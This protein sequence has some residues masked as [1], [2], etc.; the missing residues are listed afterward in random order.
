MTKLVVNPE[1]QNASNVTFANSFFCSVAC[2]AIAV[3]YYALRQGF[4]DSDRMPLLNFVGAALFVLNFPAI[5][6]ET[7]KRKYSRVAVHE[8]LIMMLTFGVIIGLASFGDQLSSTISIAGY[9]VCLHSFVQLLRLG[10]V[11]WISVTV[12]SIFFGL[13]ISLLTW[14]C[15]ENTMFLESMAFDLEGYCCYF[16]DPL[17]QAS[18]TQM[19]KTYGVS[20]TGLDGIPYIHYH[21]GSH[22]IFSRLSM[23]FRCHVIDTIQVAHPIIFIPLFAKSILLATSRIKKWLDLD[24]SFNAINY[25]YLVVVFVGFLHFNVQKFKLTKYVAGT[26]SD[27]PTF[28]TSESYLISLSA[29]IISIITIVE[30]FRAKQIG[31]L[32]IL[33][34]FMI[35]TISIIKISTGFILLVFLGFSFLRLSLYRMLSVCASLFVSSLAFFLIYQFSVD[36]K[37]QEGSI[38]FMFF[39]KAQHI[40]FIPFLIIYFFFTWLVALLLFLRLRIGSLQELRLAIEGKKLLLIEILLVLISASILPSLVLNLTSYNAFYFMDIIFWLSIA[41]LL[42]FSSRFYRPLFSK[43]SYRTTSGVILSIVFVLSIAYFSHAYYNSA[44]RYANESVNYGNLRIR[45]LIYGDTT[46]SSFIKEIKAFVRNEDKREL[47]KKYYETS[48]E[49]KANVNEYYRVLNQLK[50]LDTVPVSQ[51]SNS[52]L[53]VNYSKL[54]YLHELFCYQV[55]LVFPALTGIAMINGT[56]QIGC[57]KE[58]YGFDYYTYRSTDDYLKDWSIDELCKNVM[59]KGFKFLCYYD[60]KDGQIKW[61]DAKTSREINQ[62]PN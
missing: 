51:K 6:I 59:A 28:L 17:F 19:I 2:G 9:I 62:F 27:F 8:G 38:S 29:L 44:K 30:L 52:L 18:V 5:F 48:I 56:P 39:Y 32:A 25:F 36:Q 57:V 40:H 35:A 37:V 58:G 12:F 3:L 45:K 15:N 61:F 1:E 13:L 20:S 21:T 26:L 43:D 31:L 34:P 60:L 42:A 53:Y 14:S 49:T 7:L 50:S 23:F 22:W 33:T 46:T 24:Q 16:L 55:P 11:P 10:V 4:S 41:T 47:L 54:P